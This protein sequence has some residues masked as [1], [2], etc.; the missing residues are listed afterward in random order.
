MTSGKRR[1][2][3]RFL[4][5]LRDRVPLGDVVGLHV[6][7]V[8]QGRELV[9]LC[10]FH[11]ER[12]P[13]FAVV[14]TKGFYHCFGCGAHGDALDFLMAI[15]NVDFVEAV[16]IAATI[17]GIVAGELPEPAI[18]SSAK[19]LRLSPAEL[20]H[21]RRSEI[22]WAR[23]V[24]GAGAPAIGTLVEVYLRSRGIEHPPPL[25]LR[26]APALFHRESGR[27]F[28]AMIGGIQNIEGR[29]VGV[30][31]TFVRRDGAGKAEVE[32]A[33]K[34][35]GIAWGGAVRLTPAAPV[36][37]IGEGIETTLSAL[38]SFHD[39]VHDAALIED[40]PAAFWAALSL[41]NIAGS[42]IGEGGPHPSR[43]GKRLPSPVPDPDR[44]GLA[45]PD[46]VRR[47]I[48][49]ADTDAGD[50]ETAE[51]L[52]RRGA[53]RFAGAGLAVTIARPPAGCD[54]NDVLRRGSRGA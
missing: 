41:G 50:P 14:E 54:F 13:S 47:V 38:A 21:Q 4:A 15:E 34:V 17:T 25:S 10:P 12:S 42:G 32:P 45:L 27:K 36:M 39:G 51:V 24:F 23:G 16:E 19:P 33:K 30:H 48:L 53:R 28:P 46:V 9:G 31:R 7:L 40:E 43:P 22:E 8:R 2:P 26:F 3:D 49:L 52:L 37:V 35:G 6:R 18:A 1:F 29:V 5:E 44:P 11:A 20:E